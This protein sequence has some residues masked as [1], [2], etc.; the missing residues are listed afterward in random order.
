MSIIIG[1]L[2]FLTLS[3]MGMFL[4][5]G[6]V[7]FERFALKNQRRLLLDMVSNLKMF[8]DFLVNFGSVL[9]LR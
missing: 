2:F 8:D 9:E 6:I 1:V 4:M 3:F 7:C 5:V